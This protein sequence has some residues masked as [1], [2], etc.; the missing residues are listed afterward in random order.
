MGAA[1]LSSLGGASELSSPLFEEGVQGI[2]DLASELMCLAQGRV[3]H[4]HVRV[5][6]LAELVSQFVGELRR[7]TIDQRFR[8][9][10]EVHGPVTCALAARRFRRVLWNLVQNA[11]EAT[12]EGGEIRVACHVD[13][14]QAFLEVKDT[15]RGIPS[16]QLERVF[17]AFFTTRPSG[18]GLGLEVCRMIVRAHGGTIE[19]RSEVGVGTAF[20]I[21]LPLAA[22]AME[23]SV[24]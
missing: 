19:C 2:Q 24:A 11:S 5:A 23:P 13:R 14:G 3:P 10:A 16:D 12:P 8:L 7:S 20:Q 15:G 9:V 18:T 17:E 22:T 4:Y 21:R 6:D 1:E